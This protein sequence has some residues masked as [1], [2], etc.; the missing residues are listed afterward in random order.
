MAR[1]KK[2]KEI[3]I[4]TNMVREIGFDELKDEES[5]AKGNYV[6]MRYALHAA[7]ERCIKGVRSDHTGYLYIRSSYVMWR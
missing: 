2:E 6:F 7:R 1:S 4:H 3:R 5:I